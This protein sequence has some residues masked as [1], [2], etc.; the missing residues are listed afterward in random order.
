MCL[1]GIFQV[2]GS[3]SLP[4]GEGAFGFTFT[5]CR[6]S[7]KGERR[8]SIDHQVLQQLSVQGTALLPPPTV[9]CGQRVPFRAWLLI[10]DDLSPAS[11]LSGPLECSLSVDSAFIAGAE[12]TQMLARLKRVLL[13]VWVR[14]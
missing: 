3:L 1:K 9:P 6:G 12:S 11:G 7:M 2:R 4:H 8:S 13:S 14:T 10:Y 5:R